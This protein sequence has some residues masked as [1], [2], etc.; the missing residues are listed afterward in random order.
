MTATIADPPATDTPATTIVNLRVRN[1]GQTIEI[2]LMHVFERW[3]ED[4]MQQATASYWRR[5]ADQLEQQVYTPWAY[6]AAAAC[7]ARARIE[8]GEFDHELF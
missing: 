4:T 2:D 6:E 8:E 5:R 1:T 3:L 7:R